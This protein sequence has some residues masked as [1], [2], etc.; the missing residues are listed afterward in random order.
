[1]IK[2]YKKITS[3]EMK[4][5]IFVFKIVIICFVFSASKTLAANISFTTPEVIQVR[6]TFEVL[7]N[8]DTDGELINSINLIL[9]Y[10][11]NL[12]SF[13]GYKDE[14]MVIGFWVETPYAS[15]GKIY[16][17]GVILGGA[18]GLYDPNKNGISPMP[19]VRLLF[20]ANEKGNAKLSFIKTEILKND[21]KGTELSHQQK[22][23]EIII[24]AGISDNNSKN[25]SDGKAGTF[26][27]TPPE[28]FDVTFL[29]S[30]LFSKTPS[31]I[32]FKA[33]DTDSGIKEYKIKINSEEWQD[34]QNP[35]PITKSIFSRNITARAFDFYGNFKDENIKI[36]GLISFK[37]LLII[38]I[39]LIA[40]SILGFKLLK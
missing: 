35:Q 2:N 36:P 21:G 1:M 3:N 28:S 20:I 10:D 25:L 26:D 11:E 13:T 8:A 24:Q 27:K 6:D 29:E 16:L 31:M 23:G 37:F 12:L 14:N 9:N 5:F 7:I 15:D 30:S 22:N 34:A 33:Q 19:L 18:S 39:L 38:F 40:S 4:K 17:S 32:A